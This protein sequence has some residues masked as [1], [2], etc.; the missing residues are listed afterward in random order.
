MEY[1]ILAMIFFGSALMVV[2]IIRYSIFIKQSLELEKTTKKGLLIVP[3]LLLVFFLIGY[4]VVGLSGLADLM[5]SSILLGGSIFVF[6]L[7][8]VILTIVKRIRETEQ[9]LSI[10]YDEAKAQV[11]GFLKDSMSVIRANLT[12]DEIEEVRGDYLYDSDNDFVKY[13]DYMANREKHILNPDYSETNTNLFKRENLIQHYMDGQINASQVLFVKDKNGDPVFVKYD[14][15]ITKMP[16]SGDVVAFIVEKQ[17][18][19]EVVKRVLVRQVLMDQYDR[20]GYIINGNFKVLISNVGKKEGLIFKDNTDDTYESIYY[21]IFLPAMIKDESMEPGQPNPLRL[22]VIDKK[23]S[24]N[25]YYK[26]NLPFSVDGETRYKQFVF[27]RI[28][29]ASH[30]YIMLLS[31]TTEIQKEQEKRNRVL[32]EALRKSESSNESRVN[33]FTNITHDFS[34]S[35]HGILGFTEL[36]KKEKDIRVI[37]EYLSKISYSSSNLMSFMSDLFAMSVIESGELTINLD[38]VDICSEVDT[39]KKDVS[40][41]FE[42][43]SVGV[44]VDYSN[45]K[46]RIVKCDIKMVKQILNRLVRNAMTFVPE[47][48]NVSVIVDQ[49]IIS[50]EKSNYIFRIRNKGRKIPDSGVEKLFDPEGWLNF[51]TS[52]DVPGAGIGMSVAKKYA[53]I[54]GGSIEL[55]SNEDEKVE[56]TVV[57]PLDIDSDVKKEESSTG[58]V[59]FN[60]NLLVVDDNEINREIASLTLS[61]IGF[62]VELACD[63]K[64]A[65]EKVEKSKPGYYSAVLMDVQMPVMD[66][67]TATKEIRKLS[68]KALANVPIIAMTANNYQEDRNA[69]LDAGMNGFVTKPIMLEEIV[70]TLKKYI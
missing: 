14:A 3:L 29:A 35:V 70:E 36:A 31:D 4:V 21:N 17:Y 26:V 28:D 63:G 6:L 54:M 37:H 61:S 11:E 1:L 42:V 30:F 46:N 62:N 58:S 27:Y 38:S 34:T 60:Q 47:K 55:T 68:E 65:V 66:G 9:I 56:L 57:L 44:D 15:T 48:T 45:V 33:F 53:D 25:S 69:A 13:S 7:M 12:K 32:S 59:V 24:E 8:L 5:M 22:S 10:R 49:E 18:N 20:I 2:N 19:E 39:I 51:G 67:Y 41:A 64:D 50:E 23:L 16:V 43:K 52:V 40:E